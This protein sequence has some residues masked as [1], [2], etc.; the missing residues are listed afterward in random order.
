MNPAIQSMPLIGFDQMIA[1]LFCQFYGIWYGIGGN[2]M[3]KRL[4]DQII[5][6]KP[7]AGPKVKQTDLLRTKFLLQPPLEKF[8]KHMMITK[9]TSFHVQGNYKEI[10]LPEFGQQG[11]AAG[12]VGVRWGG[13]LH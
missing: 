1:V 5:F 13:R 6:G 2:G 10:V 11:G 12:W 8:L 3:V 4:I 7:S 9:P